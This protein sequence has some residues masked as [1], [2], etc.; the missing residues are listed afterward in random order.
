MKYNLTWQ[1]CASLPVNCWATSVTVHDE[2]VYIA[3]DHGA[4]FNVFYLYD[5]NND[6]WSQLSNPPYRRFSLVAALNNKQLLAIGGVNDHKTSNLLFLW[7][8]MHQKWVRTVYPS[9]PTS[10]Y[11]CSSISYESTVI[12]AGGITDHDCI[13]TAV[14][15]LHINNVNPHDS[16]WSMAEHLPFAVYEAVPLIIDKR[17]YMTVGYGEDFMSECN[18]LIASLPDLLQSCTSEN[19]SPV[20]SKLPD[21]PYSSHSIN[22]YQGHLIT[23]GGDQLVEQ[24]SKDKPVWQSFPHIHLYNPYT[25]SWECVGEIPHGYSFGMSVHLSE[26]KILFVGGVTGTHHA[27][28]DDDLVTTC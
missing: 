17:L 24:T 16:Y 15:V 7:N 28:N 12:V 6:K 14:E 13:T 27:D 10:R 11:C 9:M 3:A 4:D 22:H 23:F 8:K 1:Q 5:P 19:S 2:N 18:I 26:K 20:W 25:K 21:M